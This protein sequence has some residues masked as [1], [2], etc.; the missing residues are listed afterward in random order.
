MTWFKAD[1]GLAD[2][3]KVRQ[4]GR[5][6]LPAMGLWL[7]SGTWSAQQLTDGF[8]PDEIVERYDPKHRMARRLVDVGLW[9]RAGIDAENGNFPVT[10]PGY[11]FH[12]WAEMQPLA[13]DVQ[14]RR[15]ETRDR[16][17]KHREQ[18]KQSTPPPDPPN[19]NSERNGSSNA[20]LDALVTAPPSRPVPTRP[21]SRDLGGGAADRTTHEPPAPRRPRCPQ[22]AH[23]ADDDPGPNC[24][25]CRDARL[26]LE[27]QAGRAAEREREQRAEAAERAANCP[28][29]DN[30]WVVNDD[31]RP[32]RRCD[33]P[34]IRLVETPGATA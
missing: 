10:E 31:G 25:G 19:G 23:L 21:S 15:A 7:L 9:I 11:L 13:R 34:L 26:A 6:R 16:V 17:R 32:I 8:V 18:R 28:H 4:L 22:H 30:G 24:V 12:D 14:R 29:C 3:R 27:A 20:L 5:D 33:H 2:H 1:D